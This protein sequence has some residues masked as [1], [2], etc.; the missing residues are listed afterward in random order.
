MEQQRHLAGNMVLEVKDMIAMERETNR[1]RKEGRRKEGGAGRNTLLNARSICPS[2]P[3]TCLSG[4]WG[5]WDGN[6][7]CNLKHQWPG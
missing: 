6:N 1:V 5:H 2:C 7:D 4:L 3:K